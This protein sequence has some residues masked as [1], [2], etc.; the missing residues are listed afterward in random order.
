MTP[1]TSTSLTPSTKPVAPV[2]TADI[3][4]PTE[5]RNEKVPATA[6]ERAAAQQATAT[7]AQSET[8]QTTSA[9]LPNTG[10]SVAI[11]GATAAG[12]VGA[13]GLLVRR[14]KHHRISEGA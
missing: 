7:T 5:Q 1:S 10:A 8:A 13:G 3:P 2:A 9:E 12:L 11:L 6:S 14:G 4:L